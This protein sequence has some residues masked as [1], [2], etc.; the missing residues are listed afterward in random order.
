MLQV[1]QVRSLKIDHHFMTNNFSFHPPGVVLSLLF[2]GIGFHI[3]SI[4]APL[5]TE[6]SPFQDSCASFKFDIFDTKFLL[7]KLI[8][9]MDLHLIL[10]FPLNVVCKN[11]FALF[12]SILLSS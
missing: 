7:N 9:S 5:V 2:L 12:I 10:A 3:V 6:T 8:F 1:G 11:Y 4:D